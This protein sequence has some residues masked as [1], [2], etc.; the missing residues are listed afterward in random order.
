MTL[1]NGWT[2]SEEVTQ[3]RWERIKAQHDVRQARRYAAQTE[4]EANALHRQELDAELES[5]DE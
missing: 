1:S 5:E 4:S 3:E 2:E